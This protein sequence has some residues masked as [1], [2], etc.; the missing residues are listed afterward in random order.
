[1]GLIYVPTQCT[2]F[3]FMLHLHWL[4]SKK[5]SHVPARA[6]AA[7]TMRKSPPTLSFP[8]SPVSVATIGN[9]DTGVN[10]T[11][12]P[13]YCLCMF[14]KPLVLKG[15][16]QRWVPE[17]GRQAPFCNSMLSFVRQAQKWLYLYF[18][19]SKSLTNNLVRS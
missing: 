10:V 9:A 4:F 13:V 3:L 1:M 19:V 18:G 14:P 6:A 2:L 11:R 5:A 12:G 17:M 15:P 7:A 8:P 16:G